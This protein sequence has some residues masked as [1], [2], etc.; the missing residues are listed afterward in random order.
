M[1][2]SVFF[3]L[4]IISQIQNRS[5]GQNIAGGG[6]F[7]IVLLTDKTVKVFGEN[8]YGQLGDNTTIDRLTPVQVLTGTSGCATNLCDILFVSAG[9][10]HA[11][12]L[13]SDG[14]V[15][16]W[17]AN[18]SGQLGDGT[19]TDRHTPVQ[20]SSLTNVTMV[21]G[22]EDHSV[23]LKSDG[24]V[25]SWGWNNVGQ[26]GDNTT[27]DRLTPVQVLTGASGCATNLCNITKISS[28]QQH[29][30]ALKSDSTVWAWGRNNKGQLGDN[31]TTNRR[32][33]VQVSGLSGIID[34][35]AGQFH[36]LALKS[37]G[38]VWA[39]GENVYGQLGDN[40]TTQRLTPVRVVT[41]ASGCG[42][43]L[44]N[45]NAIVAGD[46][47]SL[48]LKDDYT[49]WGWGGD[50]TGQLGDGSTT[51]K[52]T[53]VQVSGL[54]NVN[55]IGRGYDHSIAVKTN[56]C[57]WAW[58]KNDFGQI[59]DGTT[60]TPRTT[61]VTASS[62]C[63]V[64]LPVELILF[65]AKKN[66][67]IVNLRWS[68]AS[69]N[70]NDYFTVERSSD[71]FQFDKV[72]MV[73][74]AGTSTMQSNYITTDPF[75]LEGISYYRLKQTDYDGKF[76]YSQIISIEFTY[77]NNGMEV[78]AYPNP[79]NGQYRNNVTLYVSG[80][81]QD[82]SIVIVMRDVLGKEYYSRV[83]LNNQNGKAQFEI[84]S[85]EPL[86]RGVY[87]IY[88]SSNNKLVSEKLVVE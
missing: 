36:S 20:V 5:I 48:V 23:A 37:D 43:Y 39:W 45:I 12:A 15:Y 25:W 82:S 49:V 22:G 70:N 61:P 69:E 57:L 77:G 35:A 64:A 11:L 28:W 72:A 66:S 53:P 60:T 65:E 10:N 9:D 27:T 54:T 21:A 3:F 50:W 41:G 8:S 17:G 81:S 31:T 26:L 75:P 19:T 46:E 1:G 86:A 85:S 42:T 68:T 29:T 84:E 62:L 2:K 76:T 24:T 79:V 14:T 30:L 33:P 34:V 74:G 4:M 7:S 56:N 44:C 63:T 18:W 40:T 13:K 71:M 73:K 47:H 80:V 55:A 88:A 67:Q 6:N 87:I 52:K 32:T 51:D 78:V 16:A 38:S 58:G 59:G 83:L